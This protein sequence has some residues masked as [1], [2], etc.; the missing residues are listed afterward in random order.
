MITKSKE[1]RDL[2]AATRIVILG[3]MGISQDDMADIVHCGKQTVGRYQKWFR[4]LPYERARSLVPDD[5]IKLFVK[6]D[7]PKI[8]RLDKDKIAN[9]LERNPTTESVLLYYGHSPAAEKKPEPP[10]SPLTVAQSINLD[11]LG[12][13]WDRLRELTV[14]LREQSKALTPETIFT[15]DVCHS[16]YTSV[17]F[18]TPLIPS[19]HWGRLFEAPFMIRE[20]SQDPIRLEVK[21]LVEWE[22]L[23]PQLLKHLGFDDSHFFP[24]GF[25]LWKVLYSSIVSLSLEIIKKVTIE[26]PRVTSAGYAFTDREYGLR[27]E[28]PAHL[29]RYMLAQ[30]AGK[31]IPWITPLNSYDGREPVKLVP[32]DRFV[33]ITLAQEADFD[34]MKRHETALTELVKRIFEEDDKILSSLNKTFPQIA[35]LS[36]ELRKVLTKVIERGDYRGSC[37]IC[38]RFLKILSPPPDR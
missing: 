2:I 28:L 11:L 16:I 24:V 26:C 32:Q 35:I 21:L 13:H 12:R 18:K 23:F 9:A 6:E 36:S 15:A 25:T 10:Q 38:Q 19:A 33:G 8:T 17:I 20:L 34:R 30:Y 14:T 7:F 37:D 5:R 3:A 4:E 1:P 22:S 27:W 31:P 29:C